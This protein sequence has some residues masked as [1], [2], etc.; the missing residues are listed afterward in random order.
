MTNDR[1]REISQWVDAFIYTQ[2][3]RYANLSDAIDN[4]VG[5]DMRFQLPAS[6]ALAKTIPIVLSIKPFLL[7][8]SLAYGRQLLACTSPART[9]CLTSGFV[10]ASYPHSADRT[11]QLLQASNVWRTRSDCVFSFFQ[12]WSYESS[13]CGNLI[14]IFYH[15]SIRT[16]PNYTHVL[17]VLTGGHKT[18]PHHIG[19]TTHMRRYGAPCVK[20]SALVHF[21]QSGNRPHVRENPHKRT[22]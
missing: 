14:G 12:P 4:L 11:R 21:Y 3:Y 13:K 8:D 15:A 18:R 1:A 20:Q 9:R 17:P 6:R 16:K 2:I 7:L 19:G 22:R 5:S 10:Y